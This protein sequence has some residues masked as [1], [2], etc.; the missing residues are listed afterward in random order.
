MQV[1]H[2]KK[3]VKNNEAVKV[4]TGGMIP[5]GCNAV[6][7]KELVVKNEKLIKS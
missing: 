4:M 6:I 5:K 2:F 7:M 3:N 1:I